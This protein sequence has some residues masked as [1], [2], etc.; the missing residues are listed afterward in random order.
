MQRSVKGCWETQ[1]KV[2]IL[3]MRSEAMSS[4]AV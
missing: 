1:S 2:F 3:L 4:V